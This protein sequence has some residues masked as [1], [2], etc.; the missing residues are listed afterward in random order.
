M[1]FA[2]LDYV[3]GLKQAGLQSFKKDATL[4]LVV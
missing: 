1:M 4:I 2:P 3:R